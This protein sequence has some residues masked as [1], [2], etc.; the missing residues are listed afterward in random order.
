LWKTEITD[1][2]GNTHAFQKQSMKK[3]RQ[4]QIQNTILLPHQDSPGQ[5]GP[6][7]N[8]AV[9]RRKERYRAVNAVSSLS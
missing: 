9:L 2:K 5:Q 8:S 7:A 3:R 4:A 6:T 1:D